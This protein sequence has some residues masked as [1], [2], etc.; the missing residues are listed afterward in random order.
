MSAVQAPARPSLA[1][2]RRWPPTVSAAQAAPVLGLSRRS[3]HR[4]IARGDCPVK[5]IR[6]N[7]RIHV[8]TAS[9]VEVLSGRGDG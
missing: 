9:L 2:I 3:L 8:V 6:V 4:A 1:A 7:G 5:T